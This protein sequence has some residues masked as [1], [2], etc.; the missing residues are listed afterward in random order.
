MKSSNE[1]KFSICVYPSLRNPTEAKLLKLVNNTKQG[2][3]ASKLG[4][5][6]KIL[7]YFYKPEWQEKATKWKHTFINVQ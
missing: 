7:K 1:G 5:K 4:S 2:V 3:M 6:F